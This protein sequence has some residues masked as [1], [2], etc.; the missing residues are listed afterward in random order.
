MLKTGLQNIKYLDSEQAAG[1]NAN[2]GFKYIK[3]PKNKNINKYEYHLKS[4]LLN[5]L[6]TNPELVSNDL[7]FS[8]NTKKIIPEKNQKNISNITFENYYTKGNEEL[9]LSKKSRNNSSVPYNVIFP[10]VTNENIANIQY[11]KRQY[12]EHKN[13]SIIKN[14]MIPTKLEVLKACKKIIQFEPSEEMVR[15]N[16]RK[17]CKWDKENSKMPVKKNDM[18][19]LVRNKSYCYIGTTPIKILE[20]INIVA[21]KLNV[22]RDNKNKSLETSE[23]N[24]LNNK[25]NID[26]IISNKIKYKI[27]PQNKSLESTIFKNIKENPNF[28]EKR[29]NSCEP[30]ISMKFIK[31]ENENFKDELANPNNYQETNTVKR[32]EPKIFKLKRN[33]SSILL[34]RKI[35]NQ[36]VKVVK[37]INE[38]YQDENKNVIIK[39]QTK[40][41]PILEEYSSVNKL[42][43]NYS[44]VNFNSF[45]RSHELK[46]KIEKRRDIISHEI[47]FV[48]PDKI[49]ISEYGKGFVDSKAKRKKEIKPKFQDEVKF[50][51]E[52]TN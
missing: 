23:G 3:K 41:E 7:K 39:D 4:S 13:K 50:V 18:Y 20:P 33:L 16:K 40:E 17:F 38:N 22:S 1:I 2:P 28:I 48:S 37:E 8:I 47:N 25:T 43:R 36:G 52:G 14:D 35:E 12:S 5:D 26:K 11:V 21:T 49:N 30:L 15:F 51:L 44:S 9:K 42:F 27:I 45:T 29:T 46:Y 32:L 31:K 10:D 34:K 24:I 19:A 6:T